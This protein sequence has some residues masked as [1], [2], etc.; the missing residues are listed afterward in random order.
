MSIQEQNTEK[1]SWF[2]YKKADWTKFHDELDQKM[3]DIEIS[4]IELIN[5]NILNSI[6]EAAQNSIP[7]SP[8]TRPTIILPGH[9]RDVMKLRKKWERKYNKSNSYCDRENLYTIINVIQDEIKRFKN[10]L[11]QFFLQKIQNN[12]RYILCS[13]PF[14]RRIN[15]LRYK[16][17]TRRSHTLVVGGIKLTNDKEK[18]DLFAERLSNILAD[19]ETQD[20]ARKQ[21]NRLQTIS[22]TK[23]LKKN[24]VNLKK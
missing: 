18:A 19:D 9:I 17:N 13:I 16:K 5:Q 22:I 14:C 21:E 24:I 7:S 1:K 2:N 12:D 11:W 8:T 23:C 4:D 3:N 20:I 10:S 15:H 6:R